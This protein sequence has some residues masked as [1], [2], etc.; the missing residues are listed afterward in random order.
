LEDTVCLELIS[1]K[2]DSIVSIVKISEVIVSNCYRWPK[3]Q[4]IATKRS[5]AWAMG[6]TLAE[7]HCGKAMRELVADY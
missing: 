5:S 6:H 2:D 4:S 1:H 3:I 7:H